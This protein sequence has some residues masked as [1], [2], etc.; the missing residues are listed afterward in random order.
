[1]SRVLVPDAEEEAELLQVGIVDRFHAMLFRDRADGVAVPLN[2]R[3][4]DLQVLDISRIGHFTRLGPVH[5]HIQGRNGVGIDDAWLKEGV[6]VKGLHTYCGDISYSLK[7]EENILKAKF[8][9]DAT[10]PPGGFVFKIPSAGKVKEVTVV[11][12]ISDVS[13]ECEVVFYKLP[14][15]INVC[16]KD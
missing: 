16:H 11:E 9:G 13:S 10:S 14:A 5:I 12:G 1:M 6:V 7:K 2:P 3:V 15:E 8:E 4:V